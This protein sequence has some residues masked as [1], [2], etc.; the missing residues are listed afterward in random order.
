MG[1]LLTDLKLQDGSTTGNGN[2]ADMSGQSEYVTIY[3]FGTG[4]I[5]SGSLIIEEAHASTY[6]GTWSQL[7]TV[8]CTAVSTAVQAI[9]LQGN[10]KFIRARISNNVSGGGNITVHLVA[11]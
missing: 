2:A 3:A 1:V 7:S 8:S 6:N 9:H 10:F 5:S 4:T 11:D